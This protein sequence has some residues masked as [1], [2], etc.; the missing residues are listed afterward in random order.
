MFSTVSASSALT[1]IGALL[2]LTCAT[3]G[4]AACGETPTASP[5]QAETKAP[6]PEAKPSG[7]AVLKPDPVLARSD[8]IAAAAQ[9]ASRYASGK[10]LPAEEDLVGRAFSV[11]VPFGCEGPAAPEEETPGIAHWSWVEDRKTIRLA[12][13][14]ADWKGSAMIAQAGAS[15]TWEAVEGFWVP[16]PWLMADGCAA[17][18]RDPLQPAVAAST[19]T[20]GLAAV[21]EQGGSRVGRRDG[22]AYQFTVRAEKDAPLSVPEDG[23][24]IVLEGRVK[25]F[26]SGRALE[27]RASGPDERPVCVLATQ[28]D[29]VAFESA[30]GAVLAEWHTD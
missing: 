16:R 5:K 3:A 2:T 21:F 15:Q 7:P 14:P 23:Y 11:R 10:A 19:Q 18:R 29:R 9:A 22:R 6:E 26:P 24:R 30:E 27:C 17:I 12:M 8:L 1:R 20:L 28:L 25:A 13:P 4:L